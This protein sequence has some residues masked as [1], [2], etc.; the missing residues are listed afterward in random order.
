MG[1]TTTFEGSFE[2]TPPLSG[3]HINYLQDF[4][5]SRRMKRDPALAALVDDPVSSRQRCGLPIGEEGAYMA[6]P[7]PD[8][9]GQQPDHSIVDYNT[10]PAGQPGRWCNWTATDDG[11]EIVWDEGEKFYNYVAWLKYI[12]EH[13]LKPWGYSLSGEVSWAGEDANDRGAIRVVEGSK[14]QVAEM[15]CELGPFEDA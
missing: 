8:G 10:P 12:I 13:F 7:G 14:V 3:D 2:V 5:C 6:R 15:I 11:R 4:S 1:Y 9:C